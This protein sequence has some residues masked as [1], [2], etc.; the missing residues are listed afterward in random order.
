M[1]VRVVVYP[2]AKRETVLVTGPQRYTVSVKEPAEQNA[3]N[4]RVRELIAKVQEVPVSQVKIISG[5]Q[6]S[7]KI[8]SVPDVVQT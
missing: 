5:H 7:R 2:N 4:H 6:H 1:Y 8:L 3:A